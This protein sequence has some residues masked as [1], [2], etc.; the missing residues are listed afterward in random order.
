MMGDMRIAIV[1]AMAVTCVSGT[2]ADVMNAIITVGSTG[3][4]A[5]TRVDGCGAVGYT[6]NIGKYEVTSSQY[7]EFLNA[8]ATVGDPNAMCRSPRPNQGVSASSYGPTVAPEFVRAMRNQRTVNSHRLDDARSTLDAKRTSTP[9]GSTPCHAINGVRQRN[10]QRVGNRPQG[11]Q[12]DVVFAPLHGT[13]VG[14]VQPTLVGQI[15]L[16]PTVLFTDGSQIFA[17]L[18]QHGVFGRHAGIVGG[19]MLFI[20]RV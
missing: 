3:N 5:D 8:V 19:C 15:F 1:V 20:D 7:I 6:Y 13:D 11:E 9:S 12:R 10:P 17:Q 2:H 18:Q 16:R 14:S 4:V